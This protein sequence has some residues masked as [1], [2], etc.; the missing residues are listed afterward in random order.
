MRENR[1]KGTEG[2][3]KEKLEDEATRAIEE[4]NEGRGSTK[5]T[6]KHEEG[7]L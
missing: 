4:L 6:E 5:K 3:G 7:K 1:L 2:Q